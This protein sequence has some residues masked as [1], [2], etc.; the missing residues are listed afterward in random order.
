MLIAS[1]L[2]LGLDPVLIG[3]RVGLQLDPCK[4]R[5]SETGLAEVYGYARGKQERPPPRF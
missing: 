3:N 2:R 1:D 4:H 5:S